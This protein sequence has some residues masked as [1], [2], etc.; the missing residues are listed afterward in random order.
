MVNPMIHVRDLS[1]IRQARADGPEYHLA[2]PDFEVTPGARVGLIGESGS[3]KTTFLELLGLLAW[4]DTLERFDFAPEQGGPVVDLVP[5]IRGRHATQLSSLRS[6]CIGFV[7]Q[8]GG[9]L[10]YLTVRE[11]AELSLNLSG[12][13]RPKIGI[14]DL[15]E[16]MGISGC[17]DRYQS[18]L[19][20][21]QRQRAAVLRAL[22]PGV[23]LLL[24]DE[25]TASLDPGSSRKVIEAMLASADVLAATLIIA[26]HNAKLLTDNGFEIVRVEVSE[27]PTTHR[28]E[29]VAV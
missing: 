1:L 28:A 13:R 26:T 18:E 2:V 9:L 11:N 15:A 7:M 27:T 21:G 10:P 20:G 19:S 23:P 14:E 25:P 3:G 17:L 5:S 22:S 29:L 24:A 16:M 8:D 4:P 6:N 12:R